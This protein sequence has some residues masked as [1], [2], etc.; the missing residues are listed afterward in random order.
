MRYGGTAALVGDMKH[1]DLAARL[2]RFAGQLVDRAIP[3]RSVS[4]LPRIESQ[5]LE[6]LREGGGGKIRPPQQQHWRPSEKRDRCEAL[7]CIE[8]G[9]GVKQGVDHEAVG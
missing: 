5:G 9:P 8:A 2:Q 3:A 6:E 4:E 7:L 1:V